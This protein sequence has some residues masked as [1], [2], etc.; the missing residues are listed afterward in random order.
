[1]AGEERIRSCVCQENVGCLDRADCGGFRPRGTA[2]TG[3]CPGPCQC[4]EEEA[5]NINIPPKPNCEWLANFSE[6]RQQWSDHG[7]KLNCKC[8][9]CAPT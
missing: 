4:A 8:C 2:A 1:M 5:W 9:S 6:L 7:R 3:A